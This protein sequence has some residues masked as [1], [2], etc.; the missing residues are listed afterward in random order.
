MRSQGNLVLLVLGFAVACSNAGSIDPEVRAATA[1][2]A[3]PN[4]AKVADG[5]YRGSQPDAAGFRALKEL[6]VRT[7]INL[8]ARHDDAP[9][10]GPLG[11][12]VINLPMKAR[13]GIHPPDETEVGRFFEVVLDPSRRPVFFHC[14]QGMDRT[15]T[16]GALYR[17]E[18]D[19]WTPERA[20]DEMREFG[21][22]DE[23]YPALGKFV[24]AYRPRG[25]AAATPR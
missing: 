25:F 13:L 8:R 12:D 15:G 18:I 16:F 11:I 7:V 9:F 22:H 14:A 6:G 10:A 23:I 20:Y 4:F 3:I 24:R 2:V 19:G 17:I 1:G 5:V 21:W